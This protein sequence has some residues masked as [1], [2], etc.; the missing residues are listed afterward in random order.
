M[1]N[2]KGFTL[3][4]LLATIVIIGIISS[5]AIVGITRVLDKTKK[6]KYESE[7]KMLSATA[8][9]FVQSNKEYAPKQIGDYTTVSAK[10]LKEASYLKKDIINEKG[11]SCMENSFVKIIKDTQ[12]TYKFKSYV[13]CGK[14]KHKETSSDKKPTI[15]VN[16]SKYNGVA[17]PYLE[18][19]IKGSENDSTVLIEG[20]SF[21]LLVQ[22]EGESIFNEVYYS[23]TL[24]G[25]KK[26]TI[27]ETLKFR[28]YI[29]TT[30]T[31]AVKVRFVVINSLGEKIEE[32]SGVGNYQDDKKPT[33]KN[34]NNQ[35]TGN[36]DWINKNSSKKERTISV[37]CK[38]EEGGSGCIR[39]S[40]SN[41]WPNDKNPFGAE[42]S[43][44]TIQ[45]N[46]SNIE[47]CEVRV[48]VDLLSPEAVINVKANDN[49]IKTF[50]VGGVEGGKEKKTTLTI[51]KNDYG[52]SNGLDG[53]MWFNSNYSDG[54]KYE[55]NV[56]DT[57]HLKKWTW[58][59]N[60]PGI[61]TS[62]FENTPSAVTSDLSTETSREG[63]SGTFTNAKKETITIGFKKQG[64]RYGELRLYDMANNV[65]LI[66]I[67]ALIDRKIPTE[68]T[69]HLLKWNDNNTKPTSATQL[70]NS[71]SA[72][73]WSKMKIYTYA[74][75]STDN[76]GG[77]Y[78][79][80]TTTGVTTNA[81]NKVAKYK[82]IEES[83]ISDIKWRACD[84][85]YNCT[86]YVNNN[87]KVD[88]VNPK[89]SI[90]KTTKDSPNGVTVSI[91]CSDSHSDVKD[92]NTSN[93][94]TSKL[95]T[96]TYTYNVKDN[97]G[98]TGSCS[99]KVSSGTQYRKR[100]CSTCKTCNSAPC[101]KYYYSCS[102]KDHSGMP[103]SK[104][105]TSKSKMSCNTWC[106]TTFD[107]Y[108]A[109][110]GSVSCTERKASCS[111]C[112]CDSWGNY[113]SWDYDNKCS[114]SDVSSHKCSHESRTA[115]Y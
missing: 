102:C 63:S 107:G 100:K 57:I 10:E 54:V 37:S 24:S 87:I 92:C 98:N 7:K 38:D 60:E 97:A 74:N 39:D 9:S 56:S 11:E 111:K 80:Y 110:E 18:F 20:Y 101:A 49:I 62:T 109:G 59:V 66:K 94:A 106:T 17:D 115:Y 64:V 103:G 75:N 68:P 114:S 85:A 43:K 70:K 113:G 6:E 91:T 22:K 61:K 35:A 105:G 13:Y 69:I 55:V 36:N 84:G 19:I 99:V 48:N 29:D 81:T 89:C 67:Y 72:G 26:P 50:N 88:T 8:E 51:N 104:T 40:F 96:G 73:S 65:T 53:Y 86:K 90:S 108:V 93:S 21:T 78:Y 52:I 30:G 46:A 3:I 4:E 32:T 1:N 112:N 28:D 71:Y 23:G 2:T 83:G 45:D 31:N 5:V 47:E 41:S 82:A 14:E 34:I 33:C 58:K 95:K 12:N 25:E 77:V 16:Y 27:S 76:I 15:S 44:I 79:Q 42:Y